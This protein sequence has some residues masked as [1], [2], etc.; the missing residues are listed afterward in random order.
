M[1]TEVDAKQPHAPAHMVNLNVG[2]KKFT[3][4]AST[5]DRFSGTKLSAL[6]TDHPAYNEK[7][8]EYFFDHSPQLFPYILDF[9]RNGQVSII[10]VFFFVVK[11]FSAIHKPINPISPWRSLRRDWERI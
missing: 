4:T 11:C 9:F 2:G 3:L 7:T 10:A 8:Q 1:A 5:L 6:N